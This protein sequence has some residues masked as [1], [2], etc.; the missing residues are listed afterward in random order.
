MSVLKEAHVSPKIPASAQQVSR[1]ISANSLKNPV[2]NAV[3]ICRMIPGSVMDMEVVRIGI[4]AGV[5]LNGWVMTVNYQ[6]HAT[7][8]MH[9]VLTSAADA[10]RASEQTLAFAL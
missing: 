9:S 5:N 8:L 3:N 6:S 2:F 7:A 10:V 4:R 1:E